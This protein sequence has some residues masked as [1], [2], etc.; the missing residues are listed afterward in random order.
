M[1]MTTGIILSL[2]I[3]HLLFVFVTGYSTFFWLSKL[4]LVLE[5]FQKGIF[6]SIPFWIETSK[7]KYKEEIK[8]LKGTI[9]V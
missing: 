1:E 6:N 7:K 2:T 8:E 4:M 3:V 9:R 5:A